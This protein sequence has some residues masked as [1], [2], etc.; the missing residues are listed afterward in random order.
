RTPAADGKSAYLQYQNVLPVVFG[1]SPP[2]D[3]AA[4]VRNLNDNLISNDYHLSSTGVFSGR[5]L[6][7]LLTDFGYSDTVYKLVTQTSAPSWGHWIENDLQTMLEGW[8]LQSR[9]YDHHYWGSISSWFYQGLAGIRPTQPGYAG[10]TIRPVTPDG[11]DWVRAS[12]D[13][14]VGRIESKW[15]RVG[16][17]ISLEVG[18]PP[19]SRAQVFCGDQVLDLAAGAYKF[20]CG[21]AK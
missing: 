20:E 21:P 1:I 11:L 8:S 15:Q 6:P 2:E 4:I 14:V 5:H 17:N 18:I 16:R 12:V 19:G 9:S 10:I 3:R 13:T 7:L